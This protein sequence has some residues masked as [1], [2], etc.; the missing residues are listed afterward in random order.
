MR[1]VEGPLVADLRAVFSDIKCVDGSPA[2]RV[3]R[4]RAWADAG[5]VAASEGTR[6]CDVESGAIWSESEAVW[7]LQSV[8]YKEDGA[9]GMI[10]AIGGCW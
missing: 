6:V 4:F 2:C 8:I 10:E 5:V 3:V 1:Q 7:L 9:R